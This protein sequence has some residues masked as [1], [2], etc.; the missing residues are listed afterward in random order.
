MQSPAQLLQNGAECSGINRTFD[1]NAYTAEFDLNH[2]RLVRGLSGPVFD[3][4][5]DT[6]R[7]ELC[8]GWLYIQPAFAKE[9]APVEDLVGVYPMSA[10]N[11]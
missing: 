10:R 8:R 5:G 2:A 3:D 6:Y 4:F 9:L 11:N 1:P 7:H